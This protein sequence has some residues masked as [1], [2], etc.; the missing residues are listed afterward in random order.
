[1]NIIGK[2]ECTASQMAQ[3]LINKNPN[4]K[5]WALEYARLY[6]EEGEIEGVRGDGAWIQSCKETGNFKF[7]GGTAVTFDQNNFCGLG[8]TRKGLKGH[9][10]ETPRLGIRAQI[11]HLKGYATASPLVN[12]CIDPRYKYISPKGKAPTFEDLAGKWAVPGYDTSKASSLQD[13]MNKGIG[14]GFD[15]I[16]GIEQMKKIIVTDS[17][18]KDE[19]QNENDNK[20]GNKMVINVHAG[21]NPDG[22]K[23]CGAVGLIRE[24]TEA[25]KVKDKVI[26]MLKAQGHTVYDCTVDNGTSASNV[27][28]KI[29]TKC[30]AHKVDL[31]VSI[32][33]NAG[34]NKILNKITT[35]TEVFVYSSTSKA[36]DEAQRIVNCI[37]ALGFKNRGVKYSK[38]LYFLKKTK[39]P[40]LLIECCFVDD[41]DDVAL[42]NVD[43]MA[44]AIVKGIT[45]IT[46]S[47]SI[48]A[49][50]N[51]A[52]TNTSPVKEFKV[53]IKANSLNIRSGAGVKYKVVGAIKDKGIYTIVD[54]QGSWG[55][56]KSGKGWI[57]ISSVYAT[58]V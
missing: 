57:N 39:N 52:T 35:G 12:V 47:I 29:V 26:E 10:F 21:H 28:S 7:T 33:F 49:T 36:K 55:K 18:T 40:A 30:N 42:F 20:G 58:R 25:R 3:Y 6:L 43:K 45:G 56:L 4:A 8:V 17:P 38:T 5:P 22:K 31:D 48:P 2:S 9:S 23:A 53:K 51:S 32:H 37:A 34:A 50:S 11:Q 54:T 24:S 19:I 46:P 14:Y 15:I 41:P 16:A 27:L 1:M 44:Q 13:A